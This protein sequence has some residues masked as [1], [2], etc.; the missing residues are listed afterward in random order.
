[1]EV[2]EQ[3]ISNKDKD[4]QEMVDSDDSVEEKVVKPKPTYQD[5]P[6]KSEPVPIDSLMDLEGLSNKSRAITVSYGNAVNKKGLK[7]GISKPSH[8]R[9]KPKVK[10]NK[11][12]KKT[13]MDLSK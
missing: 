7:G 4:V 3:P 9:N 8:Q 5:I 10:V 6:E 1:M 11:T 13:K 12:N 2:E